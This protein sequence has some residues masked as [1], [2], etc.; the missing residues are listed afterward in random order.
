MH[1]LNHYDN[2]IIKYVVQRHNCSQL[3]KMLVIACTTAVYIII[4]MIPHLLVCINTQCH[5]IVDQPRS[6]F[7]FRDPVD[8]TKW[9]TTDSTHFL[10]SDSIYLACQTHLEEMGRALPIKKI[11]GPP[12]DQYN[13]RIRYSILLP[14]FASF[15][16]SC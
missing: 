7:I 13:T 2:K 12:I 4:I 1:S 5:I 15:V 10:S 6:R 8:H 16:G 14:C 9:Q 3:A 11:E